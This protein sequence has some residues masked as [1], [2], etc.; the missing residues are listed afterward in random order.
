MEVDP[1][2][3][4]ERAKEALEEQE[5]KMEQREAKMVAA[6]RR[7]DLLNGMIAIT[8]AL[9]ASFM[10]ICKV[11]ADNVGQAMQQA[12]SKTNDGWAY[13]QAR[14]IRQE[15]NEAARDEI[16]AQARLTGNV[17]KTGDKVEV[18]PKWT[19]EAAKFDA[20]AKEQE[21][22]K[23]AVKKE[24]EGSQ[25]RY[26]DLNKIDDQFDLMDA[27]LSIAISLLAIASLTQS[28]WLFWLALIPGLFGVLMGMAGLF[29]WAVHL[30]ALA[31]WLGA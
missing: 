7:K 15:V 17:Q 4:V 23:A 10:G 24:A 18:D 3:A 6:S 8:I 21:Q 1:M 25:Q 12:E 16:L 22:K 14:N 19:E 30:D 5:E 2:E 31:Q 27:A 26:D 11:K 28:F 9:L 29:G 13:Y 20:K